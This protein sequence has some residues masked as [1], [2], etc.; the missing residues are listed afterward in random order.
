MAN[1][2]FHA[3]CGAIAHPIA[4]VT[5]PNAAI[6]PSPIVFARRRPGGPTERMA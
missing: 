5:L 4:D 6:K 2:W 1:L 3:R